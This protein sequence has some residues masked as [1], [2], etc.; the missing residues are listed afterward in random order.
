[1]ATILIVDDR[2]SNREFLVTLLAYG[3]HRLIE[4]C[5]GAEGLALAKEARPDLIITD[6]LMPAMDGYELTR[7]LRE[8]PITASTPV[9]FFSA[10]YLLQEA[11][12]LAVKCGVEHVLLKPCEPEEVLRTVDTAL[13][14]ATATVPS[15]L[16]DDFDREHVRVLTNKL[17]QKADELR[18]LNARLEALIEL[19][20]GL[21]VAQD[22]THLVQAYSEAAREIIGAAC[23]AVCLSDNGG[24]EIRRCC[25]TGLQS[26][27][28]AAAG[29][30]CPIEDPIAEVMRDWTCRRGRAAG[31]QSAQSGLLPNR[32]PLPTY[33]TVPL[34]TQNKTYGC[35][36]LGNKVGGVEF[37]ADDERLLTMLAAQLAVAYENSRL[38]EELKLRAGLLEQEAAERRRS[39]EKYRMVLEQ[40]SDG[41]VIADEQG[42]Y[43]EANPRLLEML[44]YT[45]EQ[46]L[47]LNMRDQIPK[48][49]QAQDPVSFDLLR[50]GR[51]IR[52]ERRFLRREGGPLE[53]EISMSRL[54]DG[55]VQTIV[56]DIAERKSLESQ[57][58][59]SQKLE[60]VGRLAGGVAHDFNNLLTVIIGHADLALMGLEEGDRRRR[61]LED[62]REAGTRAAVLTAQLLAFS[63]KQVLQPKVLNIN[64]TVTNLSKMLGRLISSNIE[65]VTRL[66]SGLW[67]TKVD[68]VQLDQVILNLAINA[69]DAM[70]LGGQLLIETANRHFDDGAGGHRDIPAG[71][72][73]MLA[74][75]DTGCGMDAET[76]SHLFEPFFT[77]KAA[78]KGTGLG[79]STVYG[80]VRQ[81]GGYIRVTSEPAQGSTFRVYL[82]RIAGA[83][84][85][86]AGRDERD[87]M[88]S[89]TETVLLAEDEP[90]VRSL[91][92]IVLA[93]QG[94]TVLAAADG[95]EALRIAGGHAGEIHLLFTDVVMPGLSGAE[96]AGELRRARPEIKVL[97]ASGYTGDA[98]AL[99]PEVPFLQKPF[100]PRA[101]AI[102]VREALDG[103]SYPASLAGIAGDPA[104][105]RK[106]NDPALQ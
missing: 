70:L 59:Q 28:A 29:G 55:R 54:E 97:F 23:A 30:L 7:R 64:T 78:G 62:V 90:R 66:D 63:R 102:K 40:A 22:S 68:P 13:G 69:R 103:T 44:G 82:P 11:R 83:P 84:E 26:C 61:D 73:V 6:I 88:P 46:F 35:L 95:Q 89:G 32:E 20:R 14:L 18:H 81:S 87:P 33:L 104:R 42:N 24:L 5:D 77:T 94:Y 67:P 52:K 99:D 79:L 27:A 100:T 93:G 1:M 21:N 38:F 80:I 74:I 105:E 47:R 37:T 92:A 96:L 98:Y 16:V 17:S 2:A 41:I 31:D 57:L 10:D 76:R 86:L 106:T 39:A 65:I 91:A 71:D 9:I 8:D 53:V 12:V 19:G 72:Y 75:S 36:A 56:R 85:A 34:M 4:A 50:A 60:A 45:A 3:N 49:D 48:E 51:I 101:L 43:L 15:Q 25:S 58:R